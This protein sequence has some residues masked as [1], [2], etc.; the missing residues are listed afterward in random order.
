[1]RAALLLS[2]LSVLLVLA[3]RSAC[4][5]DAAPFPAGTS[6]QQLEGMR[7]TVLMPDAFDA[8][9]ERSLLVML[10]GNGGDDSLAHAM[11][12]M[13]K[14]DFVV[15]AP[16][17][18]GVGWSV[19]D[20]DAVRRIAADLR[21]R[22]RVGE[23]RLHVLG[24]SNGGWNLAP[25]AFDEDLRVQSAC[26]VAA[27]FNGGKPP[28]HAK[29]E[30]GVLA[31][32]GGADPN[33]DS[34]QKTVPMLADK[35]RTAECRIQPGLGHEWPRELVPYYA[36]WLTVQEGRFTPGTCAAF[37]WK[38]T[39]QAAL[40]AA[41]AAKSG[42]FVYWWSAADASNEKAKALQN[43]VLRDA[44]VQRFGQ[45]LAA[46]KA[47]REE[48]A[49]DWAKT[50]LKTTPAVVIYD[51]AGKVKATLQDKIDAKALGASLRSVAAD[52][53]LPKD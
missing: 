52:R 40:D 30:M 13:T 21:K 17:S 18:K 36:W 23:R 50:G 4:P 44:L 10:H 33:C 8:A 26:W 49:E 7:C 39:P 32:A 6:V 46:A 2:A 38:D 28:K 47:S 41:A 1:M 15:V 34:A 43:D 20:V 29:K 27:G 11:E 48:S 22:L 24:F 14:E 3:P 45:Q 37:A 19:P 9:R 31:L 35:V 12:R 5:Q 16:K 25:L 53:S 51:A 42:A